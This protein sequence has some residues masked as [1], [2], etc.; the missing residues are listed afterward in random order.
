MS[1]YKGSKLFYHSISTALYILYKI[2]FRLK[3]CGTQNVPEEADGRGVILAPNHASFLDPPILG[4]TLQRRVTFLAKEYLFKNFFVG[5]VLRGIGAYPIKSEKDDF[6]S[7]RDL[8]RLLKSGQ[9]VVVFPEGTRSADGR[10]K[11]PES[12]IGFLAAR[13]AAYVVPVYIRGS[14][15][16][17]PGH[18]TR[19]FF[20]RQNCFRLFA[21]G[22]FHFTDHSH[23]LPQFIRLKR[24]FV[25]R[26]RHFLIQSKML[27]DHACS[28]S[29]RGDRHGYPKTVVR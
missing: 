6:R 19:L 14:Y 24:G 12:G 15:E 29:G 25:I 11:E 16:A 18:Q 4:V 21:H 27:F 28:K 20:A 10:M 13:S 26:A 5:T 17:F 8:I 7:I 3:A 1:Q 9:C 23:H 2:L 22:S